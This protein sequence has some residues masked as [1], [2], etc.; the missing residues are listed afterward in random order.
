MPPSLPTRATRKPV[1]GRKAC[2]KLGGRHAGARASSARTLRDDPDDDDV[3]FGKTR[4][5]GSEDAALLCES[6]IGVGPCED[7]DGAVFPAI[8]RHPLGGL[9]R[10]HNAIT[11]FITIG[12]SLLRLPDRA[13]GSTGPLKSV[14][15]S[16][17]TVTGAA[18]VAAQRR[19]RTL[20]ERRRRDRDARYRGR[21]T[22]F[23]AE[24]EQGL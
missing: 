5:V 22:K 21:A 14:G 24:S 13:A 12:R 20:G 17:Q 23:A 10:K 15:R 11:V 8:A 18:P 4:A 3:A 2:T 16:R 6:C 1:R 7:D 9:G 19:T